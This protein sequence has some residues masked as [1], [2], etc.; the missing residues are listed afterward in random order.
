M[1]SARKP[2]GVFLLLGNGG[3]TL[4]RSDHK[5]YNDE[6]SHRRKEK[7]N[8]KFVLKNDGGV[9]PGGSVRT[10]YTSK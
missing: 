2:A 4:I 1:V 9:P 7:L 8:D 3:R 6:T 5:S 10:F